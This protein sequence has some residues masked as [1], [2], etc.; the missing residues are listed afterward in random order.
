LTDIPADLVPAISGDVTAAERM[1][2]IHPL[3][4][5]EKAR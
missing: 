5:N 2:T 4:R 3:I 1:R